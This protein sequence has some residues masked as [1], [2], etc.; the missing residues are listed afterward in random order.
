MNLTAPPLVWSA[1]LCAMLAAC[2]VGPDYVAPP[3]PAF[4]QETTTPL[5]AVTAGGESKTDRPQHFVDAELS[6][7]PWWQSFDAAQVDALVTQALLHNPTI[8]AAESALQVAQEL[9][10]AQRSGLFPAVAATYTPLRSKI[11][12]ALA[13][14]V[15]SGA[16]LYTLH[17]AA[18]SV[19]YVPDLFGA[20]RRGVEATEAQRDAQAWQLRAARLA[21]VT[22]VV[23][24]AMLEASLRDQLKASQQLE[25][26][27]ERQWQVFMVQH[28]LGIVS[29]A[30]V[31]SQESLLRQ[32]QTS[33]A[34]LQRQ[35]ALQHNLLAALVGVVPSDLPALD[36]KVSDL[37]L[38]DVPT[39]LPASL[40]LQRPDVGIAAAQLQAV[41]ADVGVA[42]ANMLP[43]VSLSADYGASAQ[44]LSQLFRASGL[45]W[46]LGA[47]L[48][49]PIFDG[50]ALLHRKRAAEAAYQQALAQYQGTLL[51]AFQNVADSLEAC[52]HDAE[53]YVA[54][55]REE[56]LARATL[57]IAS[58][59]QELGDV[60]ALVVLNAEATYSQAQ[61][62]RI[63]A[64]TNRLVDVAAAYLAI[65]GSW[66]TDLWNA[67]MKI[68]ASESNAR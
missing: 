12:Q 64:Q 24:A 67:P 22:N 3:P 56:T 30:V 1:A 27:A 6:S 9:A 66:N 65:G 58:R 49:Q 62:A 44:S 35:V 32:T 5:P 36:M 19:A 2:A 47:N 68:G 40:V 7:M 59:Q 11:P 38:P 29:G 23:T 17:T 60:A 57:H 15:S 52:R 34:S 48:T 8:A 54:T 53:V 28:R 14:P 13:S 37:V 18:V 25:A 50:G 63:Q 41:N 16:S 10:E 55:L 39:R 33:L 21:L 61:I 45:L 31:L 20:A 51:V 46:S 4:Q 26:I 42:V 43:Q